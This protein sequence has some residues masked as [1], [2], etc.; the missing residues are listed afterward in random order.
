MTIGLNLIK[1]LFENVLD[2]K[3]KVSCEKGRTRL[4]AFYITF[5]EIY[6]GKEIGVEFFRANFDDIRRIPVI[7][8]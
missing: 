7:H 4:I 1:R 8:Q 2:G 5:S 6:A 3:P